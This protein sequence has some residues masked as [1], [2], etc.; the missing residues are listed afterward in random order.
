[1]DK[2]LIREIATQITQEQI[3]L[4]WKFYLLIV[5]L[6]FLAFAAFSFLKSYFEKRGETF[7]RKS[8]LDILL[9]ELK[10][11]TETTESI[12]IELEKD[13][14]IVKEFNILRR[15]KLEELLILLYE[16]KQN[17]HLK[18]DEQF[19]GG[20][21]VKDSNTFD[22]ATAIYKLYFKE[23]DEEMS[24]LFSA[25]VKMLDWF[26]EGLD[27]KSDKLSSGNGPPFM[28]KELRV[29]YGELMKDITFAIMHVENK[30]KSIMDSLRQ[31]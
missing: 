24:T 18:I 4:N 17:I 29:K 12:K 7:A 16:Y 23:L 26:V 3:I 6:S 11:T 8:D 14:W 2:E 5:S 25:H 1:L 28:T 21:K 30:S 9:E 31:V 13:T 27:Q 15:Q 10:K 19:L 22:R 20:E